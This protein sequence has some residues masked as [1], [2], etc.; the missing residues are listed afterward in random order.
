MSLSTY[1]LNTPSTKFNMKKLP[2]MISGMKNIQL[3][4]F[5]I[6]SS[7]YKVI[8]ERIFII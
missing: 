1:P 6:A 7:V 3:Y 8:F 2:I 5:P 4:A